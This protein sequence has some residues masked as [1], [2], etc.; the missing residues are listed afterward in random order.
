MLKLM[1]AGAASALLFVAP[2]AAEA[3]ALGPDAASCRDGASEP[4]VLVNV[5][6]F[7]N[8]AGKLRLHV[9]GDNP[10]DFLARGKKLKRIDL[11]VTGSGTMRV[12]VAMPKSGQ[13]AIVVHHDADG[14]K[15]KGWNDGGGFS[16]NP[17]LSLLDLKPEY[18]EVKIPVGG[19]V[20]PIDVVLQYRQGLA[21]RPIGRN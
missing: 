5:T 8:R 1:L 18:A 3:A 6:G 17:R 7:K 19:G 4:A 12:C 20:K 21:I 2:A 16:G 13:Y 14:N 11:P 10:S 9:Y 15:S